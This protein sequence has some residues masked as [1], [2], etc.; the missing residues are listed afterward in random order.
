MPS[1]GDTICGEIHLERLAPTAL[2]AEV[3]Q[4][5]FVAREESRDQR[6]WLTV[7]D[8]TFTPTSV[9]LSTFMAGANALLSV[10]HPALTRV[11][12]VDREEDYCVV[13]Y[14]ELPGAEPLSD[15]IVRGGSRRLLARIAIEV[16]RGLAHLHR[17]GLLHG[18]L[19]PGTVV[20]WEGVPMLWEHGVAALCVPSSFGPQARSLGGDVVAPEVPQGLPLTPAVDVFGWGAVM[21]AVASGELGSEAVAAVLEGDV[22]PEQDGPLLGVVRQALA[23]EPGRRPRDGLH[24]LEL[25]QRALSSIDPGL[26]EENDLPPPAPD[27]AA[28]ALGD[29]ARR[30]LAEAS[31]ASPAP[32]GSP[33]TSQPWMGAS[34]PSKGRAP[35]ER[36][37]PPDAASPLRRGESTDLGPLPPSS[38]PGA[39]SMEL[40]AGWGTGVPSGEL[41]VRGPEPGIS[42]ADGG[43]LRIDTAAGVHWASKAPE[44]SASAWLRP[45]SRR[46]PGRGVGGLFDPNRWVRELPHGLRKRWALPEGASP[47]PA[48]DDIPPGMSVP[49]LA[50]APQGSVDDDVTPTEGM[51]L[52]VLDAPATIDRSERET[53]PDPEGV[54]MPERAREVVE[55]E[56]PPLPER[57][58][59]DDLPPPD[60]SPSR[61]R[62]QEPF[63]APRL[64]GPH[65]PPAM[66]MT[67]VLALIGVALAVG[68]T[69]SAA[70]A[71]GGFSSLLSGRGPVEAEEESEPVEGSAPEPSASGVP[72]G[73][74]EGMAEI[75]DPTPFCI[76]RG[77][78]PGIDQPPA[79]DVDLSHAE[80]ACAAR[81][82]RLCTEAEW[83]RA[84]R[85]PAGWRYPYGPDR[86]PERCR[87]GDEAAEPSPSGGDPQCVTP[88]GVLDLVG[89]VAEWT[90]EGVAMGGSVRSKKTTG[91]T[92]RQ[93]LK[94][95]TTRPVLGFRCCFDPAAAG[96]AEAPGAPP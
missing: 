15:I 19:T 92:G 45:A 26:A 65:G 18:A 12:L 75:G 87:L 27:S 85:G 95:G 81:G 67:V 56:L 84:C 57:E 78:Y 94:P 74:P 34:P 37:G 14:E 2:G 68:A 4:P 11:V 46:A 88:E 52:D 6:L 8:S 16:A 90:Q 49:R 32:G 47:R 41:S 60:P 82:H 79:V 76:D 10:R 53:P 39:P 20:L 59:P 7:V 25:L 9:D 62:V 3:F 72:G 5:V 38:E 83:T 69:M 22:D 35:R 24:L 93:R 70:K 86:D 89:N 48:P 91:C 55:D 40:A 80:Q 21:A 28:D 43:V 42:G 13:G 73:C 30:Y 50:G 44:V 61:S 64:P 33:A 51:P 29:L 17:R 36:T 63:R 96:P 77:E 54:P 71:R 23:P 1:P 66:L 58:L 31:H